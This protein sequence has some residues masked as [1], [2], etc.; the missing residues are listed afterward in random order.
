MKEKD[1]MDDN[2]I[3]IFIATG[4]QKFQF[5]RLLEKMDEI[6]EKHKEYDIFAQSGAST[7]IPKSFQHKPFIN[8]EEFDAQIENADL[9]ITH[10]GTGVITGALKKNKKV[11]AIP[12]LA[13]FGEHV[14]DHQQQLIEAFTA[15]GYICACC[16][17]DK[18]ESK[19]RYALNMNVIPFRSNT[20]FFI[21]SLELDI[22]KMGAKK[23]CF[24][25]S[26]GGHLEQIMQLKPLINKYSG[27]IVTE[28]TEYESKP[29][30][31]DT[32][33]LKQVNRKEPAFPFLMIKNALASM[34]LLK[35][36]APDLII[37]T[38][39]LAVIPLCLLAKFSGKK[40]I[41]IESFAKLTD[42]TVSGKFLERYANE[43]YVQ[44]T[45]MLKIFPNATYAGSIY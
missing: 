20:D 33:Y 7:Y 6:A 9:V 22:K 36:E 19:I 17:M 25:A 24:A 35:R 32:F 10:G 14:D 44:H 39:V 31:I 38:G 15:N 4:T 1:N 5:N 37:T 43:F 28:K 8:K 13:K 11:L 40:L 12:R 29:S 30:G 21:Q 3:R 16:D 18:L 26:S 42:A 45:S 41:Y 2:H 34:K 27:F 23:I